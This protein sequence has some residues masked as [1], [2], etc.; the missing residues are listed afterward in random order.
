[1][2]QTDSTK[3]RRPSGGRRA[4]VTVFL[5][6]VCAAV[7]FVA[8][9]GG[10]VGAHPSGS[11]GAMEQPRGAQMSA[12][13]QYE[14]GNKYYGGTGVARDYSEA[15]KWY[16]M[17]AEQ[18]DAN[19]QYSLGLMY[20]KGQGV[21]TDEAEADMWFGLAASQGHEEAET[22]FRHS[23]KRRSTDDWHR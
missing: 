3:P 15:V 13:E 19:A 2:A 18:G 23:L 14:M 4:I 8:W 16:R 5:G 22:L 9:T 17:A 10:L 21:G 11:A 12:G 20:A 6:A 1:M 7:L